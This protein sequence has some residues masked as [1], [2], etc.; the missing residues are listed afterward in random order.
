MPVMHMDPAKTIL[1][2]IGYEKAAEVTG[3]HIS[4]VYRWTYPAGAREGTG[5]VIPH[6]AAIKLLAHARTEGIALDEAD[7]MRAPSIVRES[8]QQGAA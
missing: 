5:G 7:F 2:L 4:R 3:T 6:A 1:D 8:E